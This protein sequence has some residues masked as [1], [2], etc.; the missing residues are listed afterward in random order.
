MEV[1]QRRD[2][3]PIHPNSSNNL[4]RL[5]PHKQSQKSAITSPGKSQ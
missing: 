3:R 4:K 5:N 1:C 2:V